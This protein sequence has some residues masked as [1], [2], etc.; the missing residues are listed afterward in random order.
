M[1][2]GSAGRSLT[3]K[4]PEGEVAS[5]FP[6]PGGLGLWGRGATSR[7]SPRCQTGTVEK[8]GHPLK[9]RGRANM[10]NAARFCRLLV[11]LRTK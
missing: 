6:H 11:G 1:T 5:R 7:I 8:P 9:C 2:R 10:V 3:K 4:N